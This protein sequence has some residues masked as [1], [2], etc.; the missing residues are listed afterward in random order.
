M[1]HFM[2]PP[3][4]LDE[5]EAQ[6][7]ATAVWANILS[8]ANGETPLT[9]EFEC[10]FC[11]RRSREVSSISYFDLSLSSLRPVSDGDLWALGADH[12]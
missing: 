8:T 10:A 3:Q 7:E 5:L 4:W 6:P 9:F 11:G 1:F 12:P 2:S